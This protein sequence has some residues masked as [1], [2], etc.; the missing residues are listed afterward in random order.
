MGQFAQHVLSEKKP[1]AR[2]WAVA[3][4]LAAVF[5]V[6][7]LM[8]LWHLGRGLDIA[9]TG[10]YY[11][12]LSRFSEIRASS[13]QYF[14]LW[15]LLPTGQGVWANRL[16]VF[17]LFWLA[18]GVFSFG[19]LRYFRLDFRK[20]PTAL[21]AFLI[22][23][24]GL[25]LY[26]FWWLPDPSYNAVAIILL[27][28]LSGLVLWMSA[29]VRA[30][31]VG[32][33]LTVLAALAGFLLAGL[34]MS[35]ATS[36]ALFFVLASGFFLLH[37]KA[38]FTMPILKLVG[39]GLL[40]G[41][42]LL[43]LIQLFVE[44]LVVTLQRQMMGLEMRALRG[45]HH[46]LTGSVV[47][48]LKDIWHLGVVYLPW[49]FAAVFGAVLAES[50][51]IRSTLAKHVLIGLSAL[52][53]VGFAVR[54]CLHFAQGAFAKDVEIST[55]LFLWAL[56]LFALF[57]VYGFSRPGQ[58]QTH[59]G[60]KDWIAVCFLLAMPFVFAF[61]TG[62]LWIKQSLFAGGFWIAAGIV[63]LLQLHKTMPKLFTGA[64]FIAL[65]PV[66]FAVWILASH[67]PYRL[68]EPLSGQTQRIS[69]RGGAGGHLR[70]DGPTA[71]YLNA[72]APFY[73]DFGPAGDR[74]ILI[75]LSGMSPFLTYQ[76]NAQTL[77][78]PWL[79]ATEKNSQAT[80]KVILSR[81]NPEKIKSAWILDAPDNRRHLD[82]QALR[83]LGL[84][85]PQD[86]ALVLTA[87][88]PL[89]RHNVLLY[90][91]KAGKSGPDE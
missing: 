78:V 75:D 21:A 91:P 18:G 83:A 13:T 10:H 52:A 43:L 86:Y 6:L 25:Y 29:L 12:S 80:F 27:A 77:K 20:S 62:N 40:G 42:C 85:F 14:L 53:F 56:S 39:F 82:V 32:R 58:K 71:A 67:K 11:N 41:V 16:W 57:V 90:R 51:L 81:I 1:A 9:D 60:V 36:A 79:M 54:F 7:P 3:V 22:I 34:G 4:G 61:G 33:T 63:M 88:P 38:V 46:S 69:L 8:V 65:V 74:D 2:Q 50:R 76:L 89:S 72:F 5:W 87:R 73:Q 37:C 64:A 59:E 15:Y 23:W 30:G 35:R 55:Y 49:L 44:P 24:A 84:N 28:A 19:T 45:R 31:T 26:Y 70:V 66:P 48:L 47:R 17:G 68:P